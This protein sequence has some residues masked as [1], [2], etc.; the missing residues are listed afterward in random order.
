VKGLFV[1]LAFVAGCVAPPVTGNR[2]PHG[3][4]DVDHYI[5]RLESPTRLAELQ[6]ELVIQRLN[7][8]PDAWVADIGCG[9]GV[10]ALL[11]ARA[12][13]AGLV[14]AADVEPRQLDRLR[15]RI[16]DENVRNIVPVLA[17]S[18]TPH[19]P[20][21]RF[22]LVFIGDTYHHFED[23]VTYARSIARL[24]EPGG[25]LAILEYKPGPLDVGP[26]PEHK[27]SEGQLERELTEAGWRLEAR[28][29]TH[30]HHD[31]QIWVPA[32]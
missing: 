14:F 15:A 25:R 19:L 30:D 6:P 18:G 10:F 27:L 28:F 24:L 22:D 17:S 1:A 8:A 32:R 9:P 11:F 4:S 16:A 20:E 26:P 12:A 13:P 31:F 21:G 23:R 2:D 7:V 3:P 5:E 29:D